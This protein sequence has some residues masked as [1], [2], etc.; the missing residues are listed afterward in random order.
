MLRITLVSSYFPTS[1]DTYKGHSAF[2]T[3]Q[4]LRELADIQAI[5]PLP[6]Y[7]SARALFHEA[8]RLDPNYRPAGIET[9][10]FHFPAIPLLT[11]P[12]NG[13]SCLRRLLPL[14]R[15][16]CPDVIVNYWLYPDGFAAV[17]AGRIL[18]I[19]AIVGSIGSDLC[20]ITDP[21]TLRNVKRTLAGAAGVIA[22]SED[23]RRRAI[24]LGAEPGNVTTIL[25]GCDSSIFHPGSRE[26]ARRETGYLES[27]RLILF[28]GSALKT[29]GMAE[30]LEAFGGLLRRAPDA[31]LAVIGDGEYKETFERHAAAAGILD[32]I[33][34]LGRLPSE[35]VAPW[36]RAADVFCLPSYSEGCPNVIVE[37]LACG[38]P[39]VATNVG[40]IPELC[41][42][43]SSI[44]VPAHQPESLRAALETALDK[45]WDRD[46]IARS[47]HRGW[48]QVARETFELC[49]RVVESARAGGR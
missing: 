41:G 10:Y 31:R 12:L 28:V 43:S 19:P 40:G 46:A 1:T 44:L 25:N 45:P 9:T 22:V 35:R 18:G 15:A 17:G 48:G 27:G 26:E 11:R 24:A 5:V 8:A 33:R 37:A 2:R 21:F 6:A 36:M 34:M 23:L 42:E 16:T 13:Y 38:C 4:H 29:K 3:F 30:L 47:F 32:R 49:R 39:V 20:R 14:L 7:P